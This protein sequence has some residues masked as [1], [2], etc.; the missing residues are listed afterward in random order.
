MSIRKNRRLKEKPAMFP[1]GHIMLPLVG[2]LALGL[3]VLGVRL[4]FFNPAT[5][6]TYPETDIQTEVGPADADP[7]AAITQEQTATTTQ[8]VAVPVEDTQETGVKEPQATQNEPKV[9]A[10]AEPVISGTS[11]SPT[12]KALSGNWIV[13]IGA[14][15]TRDTAEALAKEVRGK[16]YEAFVLQAEVGG[17][18][19]FRV[20][21]GAGPQRS[22]AETLAKDLAAKGYP[23]LVARQE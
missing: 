9:P 16:N 7:S 5:Q 15:T 14:F 23:T 19:Y 1:F 10:K 2:V 13:Q 12:G 18:T 4:L 3:L 20:R 6:V 17:K 22:D 8:I 11:I 21:I